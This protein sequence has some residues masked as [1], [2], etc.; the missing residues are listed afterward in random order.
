MVESAE[1]VE[2]E[3]LD[4]ESELLDFGLFLPDEELPEE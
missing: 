3:E 2:S 4:V 1:V